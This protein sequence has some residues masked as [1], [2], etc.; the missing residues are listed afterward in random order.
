M[1][2]EA[3]VS[4]E[5]KM[6]ENDFLDKKTG[7]CDSCNYCERKKTI[8]KTSKV[9]GT[10]AVGLGLGAT[11]GLATMAAAV[12]AGIAIPAVLLIETFGLTGAAIG[13]FKGLKK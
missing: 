7:K 12:T 5:N 8:N 1:A 13:F 3:V 10:T 11:A 4:G 9:V 2:L 6:I